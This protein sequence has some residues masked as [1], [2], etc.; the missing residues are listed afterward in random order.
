MK[1]LEKIYIYYFIDD[2]MIRPPM[3]LDWKYL[4]G[5]REYKLKNI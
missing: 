5:K 3:K 2:L 1:K 4:Q